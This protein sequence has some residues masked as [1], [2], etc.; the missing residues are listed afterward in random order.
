MGQTVCSRLSE[1]SVLYRY[2][3]LQEAFLY[4]N[5]GCHLHEGVTVQEGAGDAKGLW[6]PELV[7]LGKRLRRESVLETIL[8][9][10]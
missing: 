4:S 9:G 1:K 5:P 8:F 10:S 3:S 7:Y 6:V 2:V